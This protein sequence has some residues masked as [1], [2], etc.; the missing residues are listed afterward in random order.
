MS[1]S[2]AA[3]KLTVL[4]AGAAAALTLVVAA[5]V[6]NAESAAASFPNSAAGKK[7]CESFV[8]DKASHM[9]KTGHT[10]TRAE[11]FNDQG[12]RGIVTWK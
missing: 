7:A 8:R 1:I 2:L 10:V 5:P 6:A 12:W 9:R 11:C 4:M 3:K